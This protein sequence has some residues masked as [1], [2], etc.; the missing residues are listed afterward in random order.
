M[1]D[2]VTM[3]VY[4]YYIYI[5]VSGYGHYLALSGSWALKD[6]AIERSLPRRL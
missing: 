6:K 1:L 5:A 2:S 4:S 3:N